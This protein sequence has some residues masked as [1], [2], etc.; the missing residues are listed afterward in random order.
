MQASE[1]AKKL[2]NQERSFACAEIESAKTLVMRLG[3]AFEEQ[4]IS[5]KASRAQGPN[6]EKL[7]E[8]VQEAR[9]I[10]RMH[11]P[12]KVQLQ[13]FKYNVMILMGYIKN[14]SPFF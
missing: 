2:V 10:K 8:E 7:V 4:E 5:S 9:R 11:Q 12:T 3:G 6:V 14:I 13:I 1:D